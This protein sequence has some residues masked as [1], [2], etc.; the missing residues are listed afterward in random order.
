MESHLYKDATRGKSELSKLIFFLM[1]KEAGGQHS[2]ILC[3]PKG[4]KPQTS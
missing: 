4:T 3:N 1:D 2:A